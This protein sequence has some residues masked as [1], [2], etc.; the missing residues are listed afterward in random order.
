MIW[1]QVDEITHIW[2]VECLVAQ[3]PI[4]PWFPGKLTILTHFQLETHCEDYS[5]L[6]QAVA[7]L[8]HGL[9]AILTD[10]TETPEMDV[11]FNKADIMTSS[12]SLEFLC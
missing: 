10:S 3:L 6:D 5:V 4:Y 12:V 2:L 8:E 9:D 1:Y 11:S 7:G